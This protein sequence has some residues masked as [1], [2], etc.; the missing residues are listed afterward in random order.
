MEDKHLSPRCGRGW[1]FSKA[2]TME[3]VNQLRLAMAVLMLVV[4]IF[5]VCRLKLSS[6]AT[7]PKLNL[8]PGPWTLPLIGS[9]HHV[10]FGNGTP[11]LF[12]VLRRLAQKHGALM[13]IRLGEV[14]AVVA[15]STEAAQAILKTHDAAFADRFTPTT[16]AAAEYDG[17]ADIIL[18]PYGERWRR[19]RKVVVQEMLTAA[20]VRSFTRV[21]EEEVARFV[22][23]V[24]VSAAAGDEVDFSMGVSKL[25]ND[26]FVR[27][28]VGSRCEYQDEYLDA[29][30]T[31]IRLSSGV[32]LADLFPSW[33]IVQ[34]LAT[35]PRKVLACRRRIDRIL[36]KIIHEAKE[37]MDDMKDAAH[38]SFVAVL[39]RLQKEGTMPV[40]L[41]ND[42]IMALMF[43]SRS[44]SLIKLIT[45]YH[46]LLEEADIDT[47]S[48]T[49]NWAMTELIRSPAA[50]AKAQAEVREALKGKTSVTEEDIAGLSYLKLVF[51]ETLRL[52]PTSPL[53]IP[54]RC[55]ETCQ[56]MGYDI[57]KGTAVFVNVWAIGRDPMYWDDDA[58]EFRP[59]RFETNG[60]DF[61]G[62]N[63]EF[64]P[65]GAGRRMCPG[66]NLGLANIE[67]ALASLLYHFD[68]KLPKG[69]EPEDVDVWE[70]VGVVAS[71]K[72]S[73]VD[74][75]AFPSLYVPFFSP[76]APAAPPPPL[77]WPHLPL[78]PCLLIPPPP[79]IHPSS[80]LL[81][82]PLY[83]QCLHYPTR[84]VVAA[85]FPRLYPVERHY[86]VA[87]FATGLP[88]VASLLVTSLLIGVTLPTT[89][90]LPPLLLGS[91]PSP[92]HISPIHPCCSSLADSSSIPLAVRWYAVVHRTQGKHRHTWG[93]V[94]C[95]GAAATPTSMPSGLARHVHDGV[96]GPTQ[97]EHDTEIFRPRWAWARIEPPIWTSLGWVIYL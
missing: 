60:I 41:T 27:E 70:A 77:C 83:V 40:E 86:L 71:K 79:A 7:K 37:A 21:R 64:L 42:T 67:L 43:V 47:S 10:V 48:T 24:A 69:M 65:F 35:A 62:T 22:K 16:F 80:F 18:S 53:L 91:A 23:E 46:E 74:F 13:T 31:A 57:P 15:S 84:P 73:L 94:A 39:L 55:R 36:E 72:T 96:H 75:P 32:T 49:L 9:L 51:K 59:E 25:V 85:T 89:M 20:R 44:P 93:V 11:L 58:E 68:W 26:A 76:H 54:R 50:M 82:P 78:R 12:R 81:L 30:H 6:I 95:E 4:I 92:P 52:H 19:L 56:V 8:P 63:F 5:V 29:I 87:S 66:I 28:C 17:A 38:D 33:R 61:R 3:D 1:S 90:L 2:A 14:L 45:I 34:M 88:P 97:Y